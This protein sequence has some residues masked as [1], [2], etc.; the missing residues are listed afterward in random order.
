MDLTTNES[1]QTVMGVGKRIKLSNGRRLVDDVIGL[2]N[3]MPLAAISGDFD[4]GLVAQLRRQTRPKISW[5]VLY[6]KAYAHVCKQNPELRQSF[7]K[8]PR[9]HLYQ[10]DLNI[11]MLTMARQHEGEERLFFARFTSPEKKSLVDLQRQF[12]YFRRTPVEEVKQFRHQIRFAKTPKML[13]R[14][15]WW[16]MMNAWPAKRASHMGTFGMS[17]SGYKGNYGAVHLSPST[18]TIGVDS[19][20]RKG[21][22]RVVLTFDHNVIDGAPAGKILCAIHQSL[23][24]TVKVELAAM[25]GVDP[26]TGEKL[27]ESEA[28][29][30]A[31]RARAERIAANQK[32]G[33][34]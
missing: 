34:A 32:R 9:R 5:N 14:L 31:K 29:E 15:A 13:R 11:C 6:M 27:S 25:V 12:E 8:F 17:I 2:A 21:V 30:A 16:T 33:A 7:V 4:A 23:T 1:T 24:T 18:T 26:A 20:P 10:H 28:L 3:K 22:G 19:F